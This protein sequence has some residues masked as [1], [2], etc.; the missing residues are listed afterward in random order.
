MSNLKASEARALESSEE[1]ADID[2]L[3]AYK[4]YLASIDAKVNAGQK[5]SQAEAD[6]I[7]AKGEDID[8][9]E[10]V[11]LNHFVHGIPGTAEKV[12]VNNSNVPREN[13]KH[14]GRKSEA[15]QLIDSNAALMAKMDLLITALNAP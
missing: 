15:R 10:L 5:I 7:T 1:Q 2:A 8:Q 13:W 9:C 6:S 4:N 12:S 3:D 14:K 11:A